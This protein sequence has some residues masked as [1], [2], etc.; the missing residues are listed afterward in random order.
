M[1]I[2]SPIGK[3]WSQY[4]KQGTGEKLTDK[5]KVRLAKWEV[6]PLNDPTAISTRDGWER[7]QK[8]RREL[9]GRSKVDI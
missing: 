2:A 1:E 5:D 6:I 4:Q 7:W 3:H 8:Y 9:N